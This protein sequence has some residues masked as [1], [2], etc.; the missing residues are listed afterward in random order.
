MLFRRARK[1]EPLPPEL[2][3]DTVNMYRREVNFARSLRKPTPLSLGL[4]ISI[5][6]IHVGVL[7]LDLSPAVP[8]IDGQDGLALMFGAKINKLFWEGQ[9]WRVISSMFLHGGW[10][11]LLFNGYAVY[12]LGPILERLYGPRRFLVLY[13]FSGTVAGF[14]SVLFT[15]GPSVG[16]S[17][18]IFGCLGA[19]VVLGFKFRRLLPPRV[20]RAFGVGLLPWVVINLV[21]GLIPD[22]PIDNAA[23]VGGLVAGTALALTLRSAL[24][25]S[26][27]G[28]RK[29]GL[30]AAFVCSFLL[31]AFG[32]VFMLHQV[33]VCAGTG[34]RFFLCY[35][36]EL[37]GQ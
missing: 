36:A 13:M 29:W 18:A 28:W 7:A 25:G 1:P 21:I 15:D 22:L 32:L 4:L 33:L 11:H 6:L 23:H 35:P 26:S 20:A 14:A 9:V 5:V 8:N 31:I 24:H 2:A 12:I 3:S 17:G 10:L 19:L 37:L 34:A 16:A 30:E 27:A